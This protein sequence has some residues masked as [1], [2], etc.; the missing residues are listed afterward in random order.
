VVFEEL[1]TAGDRAAFI[2]QLK[3]K[4]ADASLI[5]TTG[6][7][8]ALAIKESG[9]T[10]PVLFSAVAS[11]VGAKLVNSLEAPG[12]NFSGCHCAVPE[13]SQLRA[14]QMVLPNVKKIGLLY[15]PKD[16][17][18]TAQV[19][20]WKEA[21]AGA[22]GLQAIEFVIPEGT[23]SADKLA[24]ATK[25]MVG[26]V[27]VIVTTADA[28]V[29]PYGDGMIKVANENKIPSYASLS[30]LVRKGA[31]ASL[32]FDFPEG[33]RTVNVPQA[34]KILKGAADVSTIAVGTYT[35]YKLV[36]NA[37]TAEVIGVT[38]SPSALKIAS[39]VIK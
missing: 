28:K 3:V 10:K 14:L 15:N 39:E 16:P 22:T 38:L 24:E 35:E 18:P 30:Q 13:V 36:I 9:V 31:L 33:A 37:K 2:E 8:N 23:D 12:T 19:N 4:A 32:G 29:S 20:K 1:N 17:A 34:L 5:F 25:A 7:P 6:T 26:Q 21:I 27:D 11:P